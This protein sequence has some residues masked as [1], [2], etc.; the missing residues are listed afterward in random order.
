MVSPHNISGFRRNQGDKAEVALDQKKIVCRESY[1]EI[2]PDLLT[3]FF[4]S[5]Q[6]KNLQNIEDLLRVFKNKKSP[7]EN[8]EYVLTVFK[9]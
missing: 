8:V 6:H 1:K 5:Q 3:V 4:S 2:E 7:F 9:T